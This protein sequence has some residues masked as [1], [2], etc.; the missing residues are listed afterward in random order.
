MALS[1]GYKHGHKGSVTIGA[2][3]LPTKS[4][5]FKEMLL[6][7]DDVTNAKSNGYGESVPGPK[8]LEGSFEAVWDA[9]Q[10]PLAS[11]VSLRAGEEVT[12]S[13]SLYD[14]ESART[15]V[16]LVGDVE[17]TSGVDGAV[18]YKASWKSQGEYT[19]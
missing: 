14:G 15:V 16:A 1:A 11:P 12:L 2:Y 5:S 10:S 17:I 3:K 6:N 8:R 18:K 13:L 19:I 9:N 4:W 7:E